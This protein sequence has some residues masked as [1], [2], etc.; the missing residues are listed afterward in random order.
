M[1]IV[2]ETLVRWTARAEVASALILEGR[3]SG[4]V[5][6]PA[7]VS[8]LMLRDAARMLMIA[9]RLVEH[10]DDKVDGFLNQL[11]DG[12]LTRSCDVASLAPSVP[13]HFLSL[14]DKEGIDLPEALRS[15]SDYSETLQVA[16]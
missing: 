7:A 2:A 1:E 10:G 8:Q 9:A 6:A 14:L 12:L 15:L 3:M 11:R 5:A 4:E 16:V 13:T